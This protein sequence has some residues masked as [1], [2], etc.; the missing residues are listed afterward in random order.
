MARVLL[1]E[2][3]RL[4]ARNVSEALTRAGHVV[5][6]YQTGQ[7]AIH[8]A[9]VTPPDVIILELQLAGHNGLEFLHEFRSYPDFQDI[10]IILYTLIPPVMLSANSEVFNLLG[11]QGYLYKPLTKLKHIVAAVDRLATVAA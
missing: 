8:N 9:D 11:I 7:S 6:S 5:N 1:I 4:R 10:P 3:D 2:P